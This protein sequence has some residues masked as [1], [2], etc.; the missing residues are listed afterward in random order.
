MAEATLIL[1]LSRS[2]AGTVA[3]LAQ[4]VGLF[5]GDHLLGPRPG[6]PRGLFEDRRVVDINRELL[7]GCDATDSLMLPLPAG[8]AETPVGQLARLRAADLVTELAIA[9]QFGLK[10]PRLTATAPLWRAALVAAGHLPH[11][12]VVL[13]DPLDLAQTVPAAERSQFIA[14]WILRMLAALDHSAADPR[15]FIGFHELLAAPE[16]TALRLRRFCGLGSE[17]RDNDPAAIRAFVP[18]TAARTA[19]LPEPETALDSMARTLATLMLAADEPGLRAFAA[20]GAGA[21]VVILQ[22]EVATGLRQAARGP[23]AGQS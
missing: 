19:P 18:A 22:T 10:D 5:L 13:R 14:C 9:P 3:A 7:A 6:F 16:A 17:L 15:I 12:V 4:R 8:W 2:G 20:E 11:H 23:L 1:G 21:L